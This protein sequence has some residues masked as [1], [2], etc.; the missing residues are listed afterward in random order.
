MSDS[1]L[2][3]EI[4]DH[5][6]DHLHDAR[7]ALKN[8]SLV[9]KSWIPRTRKRLFANIAF[10]S[11]QSLESWKETFPDPSTSPAHYAK[12]LFVGCPHVVTH[13]DAEEGGWIT[14]FS[15]AVRL[16][17]TSCTKYPDPPGI[18]LVPF[19]GFS[20]VV[21]YLRVAVPVISSLQIFGL[22][23]SF[24]LLD[25]LTV[26]TR[27]EAPADNGDSPQEDEASTA[28]QPSSPPMFTGSLVLLLGIGTKQFI[29][30]LLSL[31][32]GIHFRKLTL[33]WLDEEDL[34]LVTAL[35]EGCSHTLESLY[36]KDSHIGTCVRHLR[37]HDN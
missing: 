29:R 13:A 3:A 14:G 19:H 23:L 15:R 26:V 16:E 20:P 31:P 4:L 32:G 17:V 9:S 28:V 33:T 35:V 6:V 5:I 21:K 10:R 7:D 34:P 12:T 24:P 8:C 37:S 22:I 25:D 11:T 36:I 27:Y 2:P 30:R 1:R 18:S